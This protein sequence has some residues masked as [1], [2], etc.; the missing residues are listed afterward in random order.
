MVNQNTFWFTIAL[1]TLDRFKYIFLTAVKIKRNSDSVEKSFFFYDWLFEISSKLQKL[2]LR[3]IWYNSETTLKS[4][5][6]FHFVFCQ[7]ANHKSIISGIK[8]IDLTS[9]LFFSPYISTVT[10]PCFEM[11]PWVV[12]WYFSQPATK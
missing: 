12:L 8:R 4:T 3:N 7:L 10:S 2:Q 9:I 5:M 6:L 1:R 11:R